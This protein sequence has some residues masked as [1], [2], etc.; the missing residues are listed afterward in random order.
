ML[1][2]VKSFAK[3]ISGAAATL[4]LSLLTACQTAP[5]PKAAS[6]DLFNGRDFTG[7]TFCMRGNLD[8][9]QTWSATNGVI[10]CLGRP[11]GYMRTEKSYQDYRLTVEWRFIKAPPRADNTGVLVHM[12]PPDVIWPKCF[13]CQGMHDHQGEFWLWG[14]AAADEPVNLKKNGIDRLQPAK[15]NPV[16]EWNTCQVVCAGETIEIMVNGQAVNK[17]TG[18]DPASGSIGIQSEGAEI[19]I[20][21]IRLEP[22]N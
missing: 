1:A 5:P 13:E 3:F 22:L 21:K 17:I 8:P 4:V 10:H 18:C 12:Q 20:S 9:M 19:E 7:W 16:G 2:P 14:G 6:V 11:T 15:E